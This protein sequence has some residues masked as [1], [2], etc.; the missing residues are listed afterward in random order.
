MDYKARFYSPYLNQ[1]TQPDTIVS[2]PY[3]PQ[4]WNRYAYVLRNPIRYNDPTGHV[5]SD[6]EDPTP[7]CYGSAGTQT[8]VG[9][10]M[11]RGNG[12]ELGKA[13][14]KPDIVE[15]PDNSCGQEGVYSS[16][17]PGW[18][19]YTTTNLVCPAELQ[20]TE[21]EMQD[22]FS[23]FAYPGQNPAN[24]V[25]G[26]NSYVVGYPFT[27]LPMQFGWGEIVVYVNQGG[28]TSTNITKPP[29]ILYDG[30]ITRHAY[31]AEN[32]A[33]YVSTYGSGNNVIHTIPV[34]MNRDIQWSM[35]WTNETMGVHIFNDVDKNM[36]AYILENH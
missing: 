15:K 17:C 20:C 7:T 22:Y 11:I 5:C 29:H 35:A 6:P 3:N 8:R 10:R 4:A 26:G 13:K 16:R 32:G 18:H 28:L 27:N 21:E 30:K 34:T 12:A 14:N 19:F 31:Q 24:P 9:D 33:W 23:R 25:T 2:N 1:F 36:L